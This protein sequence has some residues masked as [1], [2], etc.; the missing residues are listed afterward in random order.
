[1]SGSV[2]G[3]CPKCKT[4]IEQAHSYTWCDKCGD[5]LP[6]SITSLLTND[7]VLAREMTA[8]ED[9]SRGQLLTPLPNEFAN[10]FGRTFWR[11]TRFG[12]GVGVMIVAGRSLANTPYPSAPDGSAGWLGAFTGT[13]VLVGIGAWL[14]LS[15]RRRPRQS[16]EG[17]TSSDGA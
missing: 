15:G 16:I 3:H 1:M 5:P 11:R 7:Y 2:V 4:A 13:A 8:R 9:T 17:S 12:L 10:E 14:A 6:A